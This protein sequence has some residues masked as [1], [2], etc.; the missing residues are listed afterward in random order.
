MIQTLDDVDSLD[1]LPGLIDANG[2]VVSL[3]MVYLRDAYGAG[4][5]G[6]HVRS[7][8]SQALRGLGLAHMPPEL[9]DS[10]WQEVRIYRAGSSAGRL[11]EAVASVGEK[12]DAAIRE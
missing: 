9:P 10:Q 3:P 2:G 4:R 11:I 12:G 6:V 1:D 5:L 7:N 8:I